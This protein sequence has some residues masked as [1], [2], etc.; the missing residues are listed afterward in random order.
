MDNFWGSLRSYFLA[1]LIL[2]IGGGGFAYLTFYAAKPE[3]LPELTDI[4]PE[5]GYNWENLTD[6][7]Y[8]TLNTKNVMGY[9]YYSLDKDGDE[10]QRIY[11]FYDTYKVTYNHVI[12]VLVDAKDFDKYNKLMGSEKE[13]LSR[14]SITNYACK[15]SAGELM[16]C[17]NNMLSW[18]IDDV[19]EL[20]EMII[21]Y[22][23]RPRESSFDLRIPKIASIVAMA[24]GAILLVGSILG[25]IFNRY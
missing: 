7:M 15:M 12:A 21:P 2:L 22:I 9:Y 8:V 6:D 10:T 25:S 5:T 11:L 17:R 13:Y 1:I 18:G 3:D 24:L 14:I 16:A 4:S 23:I 20:D 19:E